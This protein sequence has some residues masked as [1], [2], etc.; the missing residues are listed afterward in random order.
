MYYE[1]FFNKLKLN[2]KFISLEEFD[3][4]TETFYN[5]FSFDYGS[6][7]IP[8]IIL[9]LQ[10]EY[11]F[12]VE[13]K[14]FIDNVNNQ[15]F[16]AFTDYNN[17]KIFVSKELN[18]DK[19]RYLFTLLHELSH[20]ILHEPLLKSISECDDNN[21]KFILSEKTCSDMETQA[22]MLASSLLLPKKELYKYLKI[23]IEEF[24]LTNRG[25]YIYL[26]NQPCNYRQFLAIVKFLQTKFPAS[27]AAIKRRLKEIGFLEEDRSADYFSIGNI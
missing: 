11:G 24:R 14:D 13:L 8:N 6:L 3:A 22:N 27:E 5:K 10:N 2:L 15:R 21:L 1:T 18:E 25:Y 16:L 12:L 20:L 26:D 9:Y 19:H 17:K 7:S 4:I 23:I